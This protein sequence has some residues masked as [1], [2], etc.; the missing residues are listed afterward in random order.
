MPGQHRLPFW[1]A[2]A[3]YLSF[4]STALRNAARLGVTLAVGSSWV[5]C[6]TCRSLT[7]SCSPSCW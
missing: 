6:S 1:P 7:G 4:K 5:R 2:L 3:S